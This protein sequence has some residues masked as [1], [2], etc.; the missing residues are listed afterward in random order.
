MSKPGWRRLEEKAKRSGVFR[1]YKVETQKYSRSAD[2]RPDFFAVSKSN[3]RKRIVA[4]AKYAKELTMEHVKQVRSYK[5][6]PFFAQEEG[7][8]Y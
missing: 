1:G 2:K 7:H 3:P 6:Y 5:G 4:D 8:I